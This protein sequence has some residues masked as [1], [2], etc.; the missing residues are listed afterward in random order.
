MASVVFYL[1]K[2][3][4][5]KSLIFVSFTFNHARLRL[6]TGLHVP[7]KNW[8]QEN[9]KAKP[10]KDYREVNKKLR[11]TVNFFQDKYD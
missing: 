4:D 3:V 5:E 11:D 1:D 7:L 8:D 9:Q 10:E 2:E 6:S